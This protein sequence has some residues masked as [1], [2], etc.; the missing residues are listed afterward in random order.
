M[1][2]NSTRSMGR[3]KLICYQFI[4]LLKEAGHEVFYDLSDPDLD[5][6]LLTDP[7]SRSDHH[8]LLIILKLKNIKNL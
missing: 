6:I 1:D 3:W 4:K 8:R 5:L 2:Q 7:R